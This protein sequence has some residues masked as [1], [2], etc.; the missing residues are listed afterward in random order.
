[1]RWLLIVTLVAAGIGACGSVSRVTAEHSLAALDVGQGDSV[2]LNG[3]IPL[4]VDTGNR[5]ERALEKARAVGERPQVLIITHMH[6]DHAGDALAVVRSKPAAVFWN[7]RGGGS[8]FSA[9]EAE[10]KKLGVPLVPLVPGDVLRAGATTL[11]VLGPGAA[12]RTSADLN[13][14]S[15]VMRADFPDFSALLTGDTNAEGEAQLPLA[16]VDVDV[17]KV[18]HHGSK[19]STSDALLEATSPEIGLISVGSGNRYKH[20]TSEA[21]ER[22]NVHHVQVF[23]T[24]I[25]GSI[26]VRKAR[27]VLVVNT[28]SVQ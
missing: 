14:T 12:Y 15:L 6:E 11:T 19:T 28:S 13:D 23:R 27:G 25:A 16:A 9:I 26:T 21:L 5:G 2:Y 7:G 17:L 4:L 8:L 22:L 3:E 20:P 1:M 10:A 18:G 24:D